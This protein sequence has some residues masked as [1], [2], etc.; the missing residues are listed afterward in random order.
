MVRSFFASSIILLCFAVFEAAVL[1]NISFLPSVPDLSLL[2]ILFFSVSNG[3][4]M[5]EA[6]G[7][8]SGLF[9]D[10]LSACPL[11][12]NCLF[13]TV[14]GYVTGNFNK[15]LN[16]DGFFV[17][18]LLAVCATALKVVFIRLISFLFPLIVVPYKIVSVSFL[19]EIL[20]N[21]FLCPFIFKFLRLFKNSVVLEPEN[22]F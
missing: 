18:F 6:T 22:T 2:C 15:V 12:L 7:F 13:R 3:K 16:I 17:P 8:A 14:I 5:G 19:F 10:F 11:G 21:G 4:I 9:L 20:A 1:S